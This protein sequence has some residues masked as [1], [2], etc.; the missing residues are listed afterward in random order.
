[1]ADRRPA[2]RGR[3]TCAFGLWHGYDNPGRLNQAEIW[4]GASAVFDVR[5]NYDDVGSDSF[6]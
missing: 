2:I 6:R 4:Q 1:M 3:G 5:H